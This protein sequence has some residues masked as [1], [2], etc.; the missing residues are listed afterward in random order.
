MIEVIENLQVSACK[1]FEMSVEMNGI[2][3]VGA[4]NQRSV[5][6]KI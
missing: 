3:D 5:V 4:F 6:I 1:P 2:Q